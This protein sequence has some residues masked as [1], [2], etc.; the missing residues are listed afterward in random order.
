MGV[1]WLTAGVPSKWTPQVLRTLSLTQLGLSPPA[2]LPTP[3]SFCPPRPLWPCSNWWYPSSTAQPKDSVALQCPGS[4]KPPVLGC[5]VG[6]SPVPKAGLTHPLPSGA[7][8]RSGTSAHSCPAVETGMLHQLRAFPPRLSSPAAGTK[9]LF[10]REVPLAHWSGP[11]S[12]GRAGR[13][14]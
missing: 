7:V 2:P 6:S 12:P 11:C 5:A 8:A 1:A 13:H 4:D 14:L 3:P 9:T 10:L